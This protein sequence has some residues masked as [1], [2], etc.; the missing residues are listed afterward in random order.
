MEEKN[1]VYDRWF[2][3]CYP[4]LEQDLIKKEREI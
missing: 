4:I 3:N 2:T 1:I